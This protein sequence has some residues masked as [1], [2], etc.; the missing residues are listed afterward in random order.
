[1]LATSGFNVS[2][3]LI[4]SKDQSTF[5]KVAKD[6]TS[7]SCN[8]SDSTT[9]SSGCTSYC[10]NSP[11]CNST[12]GGWGLASSVIGGYPSGRTNNGISKCWILPRH[13]IHF[14]IAEC[15]RRLDLAKMVGV[16]ACVVLP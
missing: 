1:M 2:G 5:C 3:G 14:R 11:G 16:V 8:G 13:L 15:L 9:D 7:A 4:A 12:T 10:T 6:L